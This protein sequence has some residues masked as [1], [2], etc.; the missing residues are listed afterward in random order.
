MTNF[1]LEPFI[2]FAPHGLENIAFQLGIDPQFGIMEG[3]SFDKELKKFLSRYLKAL[4]QNRAQAAVSRVYDIWEKLQKYA[5]LSFD[6]LANKISWLYERIDTLKQVGENS[7]FIKDEEELKRL[8]ELL[9]QE[10]KKNFLS[11]AEHY[12]FE[13]DSLGRNIRQTIKNLQRFQSW[14]ECAQNNFLEA[15]RVGKATNTTRHPELSPKQILEALRYYL[16]IFSGRKVELVS[17]S[18]EVRE[19]VRSHL[20]RDKII[21]SPDIL[22][23]EYL[24]WLWYKAVIELDQEFK[25]DRSQRSLFSYQD[26]LTTMLELLSVETCRRE[27]KAQLKYL[28]VDEYQDIDEIQREIFRCLTSDEG[29]G[30]IFIR[31]GDSNQ[32]IYSFRG[33]RHD[34][35]LREQDISKTNTEVESV[36]LKVN[37]RSNAEVLA[38]VNWLF[39]RKKNTAGVENRLFQKLKSYIRLYQKGASS[40]KEEEAGV[41][42]LVVSETGEPDEKNAD[43]DSGVSEPEAPAKKN[44]SYYRSL[45]AECIFPDHS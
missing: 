41:F 20:V 11:L 45:E 12:P 36:T 21:Y 18:P 38:F 13:E 19:A 35:F 6:D 30:A 7:F 33:A 14:E 24:R 28:F 5:K 27:I 42:V 37:M 4:Y 10:N 34:K 17:L 25:Q 8:A 26:L 23:Q 29:S 31:V 16:K 15:I 43:R 2:L 3:A 39:E 40:Q 44:I 22:R 1:V 32:S 9:Y